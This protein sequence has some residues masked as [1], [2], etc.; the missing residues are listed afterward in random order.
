MDGMDIRHLNSN[1]LRNQI[2]AVAQEPILFS[3]T[4]RSNILYGLRT[5]VDE[6][7]IDELFERVVKDSYVDD[8]VQN[9][10]DGY[11]TVIGQRGMTL[12]GGQR[13]RVAIARA[14]IRVS[15]VG[16]PTGGE[17][18]DE[19]SQFR[20]CFDKCTIWTPYLPISF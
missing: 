10:P 11:D 12:S 18:G 2:A 9:L 20:G 16:V 6:H 17:R 15:T 8:F 3:G 19:N 1:W 14:L 13:Q 7:L 4:I 5:D